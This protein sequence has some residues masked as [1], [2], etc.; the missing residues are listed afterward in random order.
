MQEVPHP[1]LPPQEVLQKLLLVAGS[2]VGTVIRH[3]GPAQSFWQWQQQGG[4]ALPRGVR[5]T[6]GGVPHNILLCG[7]L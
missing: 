2:C 5:A 4:C 3:L 1:T 7:A 6:T